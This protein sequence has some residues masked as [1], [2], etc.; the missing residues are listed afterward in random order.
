MSAS[1]APVRGGSRGR[2]PIETS[3]AGLLSMPVPSPPRVAWVPGFPGG[4]PGGF[5]R[6]CPLAPD[7]G[8]EASRWG[9]YGRLRWVT[10]KL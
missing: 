8:S 7:S 6:G 5:G 4:Q 1:P 2:L 3:T 9:S 10:L